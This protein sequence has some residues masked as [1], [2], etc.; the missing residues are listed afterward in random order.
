MGRQ[1][2]G[3]CLSESVQRSTVVVRKQSPSKKFLFGIA[4]PEL[5]KLLGE[6][7]ISFAQMVQ[8]FIKNIFS[9]EGTQRAGYK[10]K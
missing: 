5:I 1:C 9:S 4:I 10:T 7:K 8:Q 3:C 2:V 6:K